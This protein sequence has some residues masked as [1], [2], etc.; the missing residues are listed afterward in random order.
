MKFPL[1]RF[2]LAALP[3]LVSTPSSAAEKRYAISDFDHV[4]VFGPFTVAIQTGTRC[5]LSAGSQPFRLTDSPD[6][7]D[8]QRDNTA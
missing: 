1:F 2:A 8:M 7:S 6:C 3:M 5:T 4:Q